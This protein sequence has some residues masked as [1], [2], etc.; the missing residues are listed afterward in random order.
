MN[1]IELAKQTE[2]YSGGRTNKQ[3]LQ[4]DLGVDSMEFGK[5][6]IEKAISVIST[7]IANCEKAQMKFSEGTSQH[8]LLR[9][10]IKALNIS[11]SLLSG[12]KAIK[13]TNKDL[14]EA[15]P[16]IASIISKTTKAQSKYDMGSSQFNRFEPL[17]QA[18]LIS[19]AY[20]EKESGDD[21]M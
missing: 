1:L 20:I 6:D 17:I 4:F 3:I 19:K 10:R 12:D 5:E 18:M 11:K 9:N 8:S 7:T 21:S 13:H 14:R 16:P 15:L 2:L